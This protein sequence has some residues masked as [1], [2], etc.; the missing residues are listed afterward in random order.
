MTTQHHQQPRTHATIHTLLTQGLRNLPVAQLVEHAILYE[1]AQLSERGALHV[2]TGKFTGR[3]PHDRFFVRDNTT[4]H[5]ID[6]G[7]NNLAIEP[8]VFN[9][10][11]HKMLQYFA[12][13]KRFYIRDVFVGAHPR[14]RLRLRAITELAWHN[15]FVH[16]LFLRPRPDELN[17]FEPDWL[18]LC[19][20]NFHANPKTDGVPHENFVIINFSQQTILIG[21]TAYSGE[22]K[23]SLFTTM[24]FLLPIHHNILTMHCSANM[25]KDGRVAL[26]FGLSGTGKTT[27]SSDVNRL[28]IGDD[29]HGWAPDGIFNFEGGC[30]AKTIHLD[31]NKEPLIYEAIRFP[32][33]VENVPFF[34][35][36]RLPNY[37]SD[38][39]TENT[40]AAYP[41]THLN[42]HYVATGRGD[43]PSNIFFLTYDAHGA[44]PPIAMLTPEEAYIFFLL[45]Y[46]SKVAGTEMGITQP[47]ITFSGCFGAP[48]MPLPHTQYAELLLQQIQTYRVR[49]WL[50]NTGIVGD[51]TQ[52]GRIALPLTRRL[53]Q[54]AING[55]LDTVPTTTLPYF[56]FR[57]PTQLPALPADQTAILDPRTQWTHPEDWEHAARHLLTQF[58]QR[59]EKKYLN[60]APSQIQPF[61][62]KWREQ[63]TAASPQPL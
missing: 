58:I 5:L 32:A 18:L 11:F 17:A 44:L 45:G 6:W 56:G 49:T 61:L 51:P 52:C 47:Q 10:L 62:Q 43:H 34:P 25:G 38:Q 40:R 35:G 30:Y 9:R 31:P 41:L 60:K 42:N 50:L 28:L 29:E 57:I 63:L 48:F 2:D 16:H 59:L 37:D 26:F 8:E 36:T 27:L 7:E 15:L 22:I 54:A 21:G 20:P 19:A 24:N 1:K 13:L 53:L 23:K 46:T 33:I 55:E 39:R 3:A 12:Q 14:Y 4:E